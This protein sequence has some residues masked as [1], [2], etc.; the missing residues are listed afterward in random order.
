MSQL[1]NEISSEYEVL[2]DIEDLLIIQPEN[3]TSSDLETDT[4]L[5]PPDINVDKTEEFSTKY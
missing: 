2:R 3:V 4:P 5:L 1:K